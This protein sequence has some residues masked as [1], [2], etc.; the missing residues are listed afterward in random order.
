MLIQGPL[1]V[2]IVE[3]PD[4]L[5]RE[6][7]LTFTD[8]FQILSVAEQEA[9]LRAY[10]DDLRELIEEQPGDSAER[11]GMLTILQVAEQLLPHVATGDL[12]LEEPIVVEVHPEFSLQGGLRLN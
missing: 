11:Q 4:G 6:L 10:V 1:T 8:A 12:A 9:T 3:T 7:H 5:S 2:S